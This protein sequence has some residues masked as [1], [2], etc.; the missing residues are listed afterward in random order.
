[1]VMYKIDRRGRGGGSKNSSLGRTPLVTS[2]QLIWTNFKLKDIG[3]LL[4][5]NTTI[6]SI[7]QQFNNIFII[8]HLKKEERKYYT[9]WCVIIRIKWVV[10]VKTNLIELIKTWHGID[11]ETFSYYYRASHII[12][13]YLYALK[14]KIRT[15][16][17]KNL[18]FSA[19]NILKWFI[20]LKLSD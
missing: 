10:S 3:Y 12:S 11:T 14:T 19:K 1:M 2:F 7:L 6:R 20:L 8:R 4:W 16:Y 9:F 13:D 17:L 15:L 18:A 5:F